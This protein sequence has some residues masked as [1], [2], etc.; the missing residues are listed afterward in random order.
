L[1]QQSQSLLAQRQRFFRS[2][3]LALS[4]VWLPGFFQHAIAIVNGVGDEWTIDV[5]RVDTARTISRGENNRHASEMFL[6]SC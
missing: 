1:T 5:L 4:T 2:S 3:R 6:L